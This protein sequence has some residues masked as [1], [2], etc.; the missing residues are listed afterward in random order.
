MVNISRK[1]W[2]K[3]GVEVIIFNGKKWLNEKHI[4]TQLGHANLPAITLQCSSDL[5][6]Q[7]QEL[8]DCSNYQTC[9]R[10]LKEYF[11]IQIIIDYRKTTALNFKARLGFNQHDP[12]MT[13]EQSVLSKIVTLFPAEDIILQHNVLGYRIDTY[14]PKYKL[15]IEVDELGHSGRDIDYEIE[16]QKAL[17]KEIVCKFIRINSAKESF[18]IF[19]ETGK[20]HSFFVKS[21]KNRLKSP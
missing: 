13:Q 2:E 17:E 6:K 19:V 1:T 11:A 20:I 21:T 4:E 10:F 7:R 3:N 9:R 5:R 18:N 16:R 14:F 15:A 8:Q 12:I